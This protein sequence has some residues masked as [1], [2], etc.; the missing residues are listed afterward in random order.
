MQNKK[1]IRIFTTLILLISITI[2]MIASTALGAVPVHHK[3]THAYIGATPNPVGVSQ[4]TLIHVG[5]TDELELVTDGWEGLTLTITKPDNTTETLGPFR[6]DATGGTGTVYTPTIVGTYYLQ[7]HFPAQWYNWSLSGGADI[8]YE[9][10]DSQKM[11][12]IVQEEQ[13]TYWQSAPLPTEYWTRPIDSQLREWNVISANWVTS[14]PNLYTPYNDLAPETAHILWAKQLATGG[15]A[16][17]E[18][19]DHAFESGDAYEGKYQN[20]VIIAGNLYYNLYTTPDRGGLEA[21]GMVAVDLRTGEELWRRNNTRVDFGQVFYWDSFNYHGVFAYIWNVDGRNWHAYD[22]ETGDY[23]YSIEDVPSGTRVYGPNGEI[24]IYTLDLRNGGM[25]LW[26]STRTSNPQE[27]GD[28]WDGSWARNLGRDGYDRVY[29]AERGI[30]WNVTIPEGLPGS[31]DDAYFEDIIVGTYTNSRTATVNVQGE[32]DDPVP[33][34][35]ISLKPGQ[36]GQLIYNTTWNRPSGNLTI[37]TGPTSAEDRVF[38]LWSKELRQFF[39]FD[40]DTG[41]Q[42][43][44][45][46]TQHYLDVFGMRSFIAYNKLYAQGMSGIM[47]CYDVNTGNLLWEYSAPDH[48]GEV[49]WAND[50][51]IRPLFFTD[52]KVYMG[53]TEHSPVDPKP[54]GGPFVCINA[55]TGEEI[56]RANGLFR[57]TD[58]GGRAI[59]G[60]SIIATMDTYDN[61]I[62]S[63]GKGPSSLTVSA[64]EVSIDLDSSL[65]I[66]GTVMDI[67]AGTQS[68]ELTARFP[69]GVPAVSDECMSEWML[70]VYKQFQRP[71]NATGVP[72]TLDVLDSNGNYRNIGTTTSNADGF[73]T[74]NWKPDIDGTYTVYASFAGSE[75]YYPSHALTSFVVG[76]APATPTTQSQQEPSMADQYFLPMSAAIIVVVIIGIAISLLSLRKRQ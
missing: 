12:L 25:T 34:W 76:S 18:L 56:F 7:S 46:D 49:L 74:F 15:L 72:V 53:Q 28:S 51:S 36:E 13:A 24:Y 41:K 67:S 44:Q 62:Y 2:P 57:Q 50:W 45:T 59:I 29:P 63:I 75:A 37:T 73:F 22:A 61:R 71:A 47:Y 66:R 35:A 11:E 6:T 40:M 54:R 10:S 27:R 20:S 48:L 33:L 16:G 60:D 38:T 23:V 70:Y 21:Q 43:W 52:G 17:G 9:A 58:W 14:P 1:T 30:Q 68:Q 69:S 64:P 42:I 65:V 32:S 3:A 55:T 4:E 26:N 39:G 5:I 8:Y 31:V 19:G